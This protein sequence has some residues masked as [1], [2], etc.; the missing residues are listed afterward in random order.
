MKKSG[1]TLAEVLIVLVVIGIIAAM[2]IPTITNNIKGNEYRS[3]LKKAIAAGNQALAMHVVT[4][5]E[6]I[7]AAGPGSPSYYFE[8]QLYSKFIGKLV[9]PFPGSATL[10]AD[11]IEA[12]QM[13]DGTVY[14][15][16]FSNWDVGSDDSPSSA[17][18][19]QNSVACAK[20]FTKP[21]LYVDVNGD[22]GPN[23]ITTDAKNPKDQYEL[24]MYNQKI[25]PFGDAAQQFLYKKDSNN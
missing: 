13:N 5:G 20:D 25:I 1:F 19:T 15:V 7:R 9:A 3:A 4:E 2:T 16:D 8:R 17:C 18:N 12:A 21:N 22:K 24:M 14:C 23:E 6:G 10:C 11:G